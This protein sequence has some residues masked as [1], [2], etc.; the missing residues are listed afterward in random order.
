MGDLKRQL[1]PQWETCYWISKEKEKKTKT[2]LISGVIVASGKVS[3]V[4]EW[5][6]NNKDLFIRNHLEQ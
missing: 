6:L 1:K 4:E 5:I 3:F 2:K